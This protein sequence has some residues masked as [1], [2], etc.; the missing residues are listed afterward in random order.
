MDRPIPG[1]GRKWE[2]VDVFGRRGGVG[3][4]GGRVPRGVGGGLRNGG[5]VGR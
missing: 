5:R 1:K 3:S 2:C 4:E